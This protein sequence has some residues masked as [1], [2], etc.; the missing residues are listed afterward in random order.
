MFF[1]QLMLENG[2]RESETCRKI[3][4]LRGPKSKAGGDPTKL[5]S[6]SLQSPTIWCRQ[7]FSA[8]WL[9]INNLDVSN[10]SRQ[11]LLVVVVLIMKYFFC[12]FTLDLILGQGL[13]LG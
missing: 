6:L 11:Q 9:E 12:M 7:I 8:F 10:I 3:N 13:N 5:L 1:I 4:T 2:T